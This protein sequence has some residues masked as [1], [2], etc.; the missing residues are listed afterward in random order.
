M[1]TPNPRVF[2]FC[3]VEVREVERRVTRAGEPLALEPKT[4]RVLVHFL[5]HPGHLVTKNELLDAVWGD[6]AVTESSLTR[7]IALLRRALEDDPHQPRFI[8][9]VSTAGYRMICAVQAE[10]E[11]ASTA[12]ATTAD[13][14][15][16]K[17]PPAPSKTRES[18]FRFWVS[19]GIGAVALAALL[20]IAV[21]HLRRPLGRST[22]TTPEVP[23]MAVP[24]T[25]YRGLALQ[26]T[27][28]PD[29]NEVAFSWNGE[30]QSH[31]EIY[32]KLIGQGEP[33]CLNTGPLGG[34]SPA[35]SPDGRFIAYYRQS[36][37][38]NTEVCVI[39]ALGGPVR[40]LTEVHAE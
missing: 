27:F 3:D 7:A 15:P 21:A 32:R 29:G 13:I 25:A 39:P 6:A 30:T 26:P 16:K 5:H 17:S 37:S 28:S 18:R 8:E 4:Y 2:R 40:P 1:T 12:V 11:L 23:V 35:W 36:R 31:Y 22:M 9:T 38:G 19:L 20:I 10:D 34:Y 24:L 33:L 14:E